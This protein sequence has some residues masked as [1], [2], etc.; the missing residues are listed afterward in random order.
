[1]N[2]LQFEWDPAKAS[3]NAREH[4]VSFEE[5]TTVWFDPCRIV[6]PDIVHSTA[7]EF[8]EQ[9]LGLSGKLGLLLVIFTERDE[10]IRIIS[11]RRAK[12]AEARRYARQG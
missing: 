10:A 11:A 9:A 12:K 7:E 2:D 8:R 5:A 3:R 6:E 1:L 4:R